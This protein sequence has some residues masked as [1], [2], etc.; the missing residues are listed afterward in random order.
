[1]PKI[2]EAFDQ[3]HELLAWLFILTAVGLR[4]GGLITETTMLILFIVAAATMTG[5]K[6]RRIKAPGVEL[7]GDRDD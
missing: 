6:F 5:F 1:M 7:E 3:G 4:V 2:K